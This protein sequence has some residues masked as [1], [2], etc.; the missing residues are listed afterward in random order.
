MA[1]TIV[2]RDV[3]SSL[4]E[5]SGIATLAILMLEGELERSVEVEVQVTDITTIGKK[6]IKAIHV[7]SQRLK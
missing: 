4:P 2:A 5:E 3:P 6:F 1:V 7:C